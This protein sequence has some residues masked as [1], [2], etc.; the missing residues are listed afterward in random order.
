MGL[1]VPSPPVA[2]WNCPGL[3]IS[4]QPTR[5]SADDTPVPV[6]SPTLDAVPDGP[7]APA[8]QVAAALLAA[9]VAALLGLPA[10]GT[11]M[12]AQASAAAGDAPAFADRVPAR[13]T[14]VVR[15]IRTDRWCAKAFCTRTEAWEKVQ[16]TWQLAR[17][18]DGTAAVFRSTIGPR[19]FAAPGRRRQGD[20]KSPTGIYRIKVTFTTGPTNPGA[21]PWRRRL[22]TSNVTNYPGRLYNVWIEERGRTDGDR[23]SMRSGFWVDYNH[24]RFLGEPGPRAVPGV[25]SGIFYHTS[26]PG[27]RWI[28]TEGCTQVGKPRQMRWI[29]RW[30]RPAANPRVANNV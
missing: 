24:A 18:A 25:G 14:Q 11:L 29:L 8:R 27:Q 23:P 17:T 5:G 3:G 21:M 10:G 6:L 7:T 12:P 4:V 16:G 13:T 19:G 2:G 9:L 30:L 20:G 15:T 28:A 22:P 26:R 1:T